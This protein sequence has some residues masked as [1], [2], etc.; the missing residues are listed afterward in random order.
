V[1]GS[2]YHGNSGQD[3]TSDGQSIGSLGTTIYEFHAEYAHRGFSVR[4]LFT[5]AF[6]DN[7]NSLNKAGKI[8]DA[9]STSGDPANFL[10]ETLLGWYVEG[11]YDVLPLLLPDTKM[12]LE[13]FFRYERLAT[14]YRMQS[15]YTALPENDQHILM[16]GI[17]FKPIDSVVIK[18]DYRTFW[19]VSNG[20]DLDQQIEV[21]VGF[22]F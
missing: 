4:A 19:Q 13:P 7:P 14:Q 10:A 6:I 8:Q 22:I 2:V 18:F 21:G 11:G 15:G 9:A 20:V 1:G 3:K 17:G 12:S 5:Q 16:V